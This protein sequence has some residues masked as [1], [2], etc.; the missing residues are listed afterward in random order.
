MPRSLEEWLAFQLA[1]SRNEIVLGLERVAEVARQLGLARPAPLVISVAGTNGKG[2]T[3]AFLDAVSRAAGH[4]VGAYTSPHLLRYNERIRIAGVEAR[5]D[6]ICAAFERVEEG[7]VAADVPLTYFEYGTLAALDLFAGARLDLAILEVGLGGRLDAVNIVDADVAIVTGIDLDHQQWLGNDRDAIAREKAGIFRAGAFAVL[8]ERAPPLS[9]R[10]RAVEV[11]AKIV[12]AGIDYD[13]TQD[14]GEGWTWRHTEGRALDLP[15]PGLRGTRQ[16]A[17]A[18]AAI[19]AL[20]AVRTRLPIGQDAFAAGVRDVQLPWRLQHFRTAGRDVVLD[21]GH[22]PQAARVLS[23]HL[24][25]CH[26][27][28]PVVAVF[29][30]LADKDTAAIVAALQGCVMHWYCGGLDAETARGLAGSDLARRV[31]E[32]GAP[33]SAH[34]TVSDAWDAACRHAPPE[35]MVIAF[36]SFFL[37]SKLMRE[38]RIA[39]A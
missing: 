1:G 17:N 39:C 7:R 20:D 5:D 8:A 13:W 34:A 15:T 12:A 9:L 31:R 38:L 32:A 37:A 21:V 10:S 18:S 25:E 24:R 27:A 14:L 29:G 6:A 22:N 3:V 36:G 23:E 35:A 16:L 28:S 26:A 19:A 4:R 30:C 2:S 33:A 11:N